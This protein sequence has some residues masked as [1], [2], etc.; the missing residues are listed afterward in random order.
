MDEVTAQATG[1]IPTTPRPEAWPDRWVYQYW[2]WSNQLPW[3]KSGEWLC[4]NSSHYKSE[5][6]AIEAGQDEE[7]TRGGP[8]RIIRIPGSDAKGGK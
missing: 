4:F 1:E 8:V 5:K 2:Y 6:E 7:R 3:G